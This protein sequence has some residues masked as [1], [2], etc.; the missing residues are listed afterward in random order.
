[1]P[2]AASGISYIRKSGQTSGGRRA[3]KSHPALAQEAQQIWELLATPQTV[4]SLCKSLA[5]RRHVHPAAAE[6]AEL[7]DDLLRKEL[8]EV[9]PDS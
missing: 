3:I 1:M 6:V 4:Q 9:S 8:I 5:R 2:E 7:L